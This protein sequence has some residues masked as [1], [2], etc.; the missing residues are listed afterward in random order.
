M[1][2]GSVET[3]LIP[4]VLVP[5]HGASR[6]SDQQQDEPSDHER[7]VRVSHERPDADSHQHTEAYTRQVE[8]TLGHDKADVEEEVRG[9]QEGKSCERKA[10]CYNRALRQGPLRRVTTVAL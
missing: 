6:Q 1:Y 3:L 5:L 7:L 2:G 9:E 4:P 8:N 10:H